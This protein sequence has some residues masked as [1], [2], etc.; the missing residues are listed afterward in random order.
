MTGKVEKLVT[1]NCHIPHSAP[2]TTEVTDTS[3]GLL[4]LL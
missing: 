3:T 4:G 2:Y 1:L